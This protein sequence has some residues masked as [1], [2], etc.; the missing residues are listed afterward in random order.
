[1][2]TP[3]EWGVLLA[4]DV[5]AREV[6]AAL[7]KLVRIELTHVPRL[8]PLTT[9]ELA[10]KLYPGH[11][12]R[13]E[14]L[15]ARNRL[16][17]A[18]MYL[19]MTELAD[20]ATKGAERGMKGFGRKKIKPWLWHCSGERNQESFIKSR[21]IALKTYEKEADALF[22]RVA[23]RLGYDEALRIFAA[24]QVVP[25]VENKETAA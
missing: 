25:D 16:Y 17:Q 9:T 12:A 20:C 2:T 5:P 7:A 21:E 18:L 24:A 19:A 8:S 15:G 10:E 13:G 23:H 14:G 1:M 6:N 3:A 22:R 11:L 4:P